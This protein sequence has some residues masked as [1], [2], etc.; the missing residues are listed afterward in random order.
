MGMRFGAHAVSFV[1]GEK[2]LKVYP[3][4]AGE[5]PSTPGGP[6]SGDKE[7]DHKAG[8]QQLTQ[9]EQGEQKG[10]VA[11]DSKDKKDTPAENDAK[12]KAAGAKGAPE[13]KDKK[14]TKDK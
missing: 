12:D 10:K 14:E 6:P 9:L 3:N 4:E 8:T 1:L 11:A 13:S 7:K 5:N 2:V